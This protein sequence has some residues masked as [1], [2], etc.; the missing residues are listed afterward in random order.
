MKDPVVGGPANVKLRQAFAEVV[1]KQAIIDK[2][3][4]GSRK[5]ATGWTHRACPGTRKASTASRPGT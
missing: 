1:D 3:Y 5:V 2:T 4:N